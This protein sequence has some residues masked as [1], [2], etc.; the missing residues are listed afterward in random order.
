MT[1][2]PPE[3]GWLLRIRKAAGAQPFPKGLRSV[4]SVNGSAS[5]IGV[6]EVGKAGLN[7]RALVQEGKG[8]DVSREVLGQT[9]GVLLCLNFDSRE[10]DPYLLRL[11]D[12]GRLTIDVKEVVGLSVAR[13]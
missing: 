3:R 9:G 2:A 6:K 1:D 4:K 10:R 11:D 5:G 7:P 8:T 12:P 13:F